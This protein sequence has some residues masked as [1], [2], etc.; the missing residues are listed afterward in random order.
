M[1]ASG[2]LWGGWGGAIA[3]KQA[4]HL[5][6]EWRTWSRRGRCRTLAI[7]WA[8][9]ARVGVGAGTLNQPLPNRVLQRASVVCTRRGQT[10]TGPNGHGAKMGSTWYAPP[11]VRGCGTA[12]FAIALGGY[13][14]N[15]VVEQP[16]L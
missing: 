13:P 7:G 5:W 6:S 1:I 14:L 9:E 3:P 15:Q 10:G 4:P 8:D 2:E 16:S 11:P 12:T